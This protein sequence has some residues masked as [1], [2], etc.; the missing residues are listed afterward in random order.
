MNAFV[1]SVLAELSWHAALWLVMWLPLERT[2]SPEQ[3]GSSS[4][5][6]GQNKECQSLE[7]DLL[8]SS[9]KSIKQRSSLAKMGPFRCIAGEQGVTNANWTFMIDAWL[10]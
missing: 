9:A 5:L 3:C 7:K 6:T 2:A 10:L 4:S 1:V 8:T